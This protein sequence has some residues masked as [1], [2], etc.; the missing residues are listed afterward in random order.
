MLAPAALAAAL[1]SLTSG[2]RLGEHL[3]NM[4][5]LSTETI[6]ESL[7]LQQGLP[8]VKLDPEAVPAAVAHV[9]PQRI[10]RR[11]KV[12]PFRV[13]EGSLFLAGPEIP[14]P[15]MNRALRRFTSLELCFHL[16]T[17]AR[18]EAL[19]EALL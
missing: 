18:F 19:A 12:L 8:L 4:G 3:A 1:D 5:L 2:T 11:W 16:V 7:S 14:T 9:L 17:P 10:A 13:A 6:Y 15:E